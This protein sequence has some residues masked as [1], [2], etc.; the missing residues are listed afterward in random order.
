MPL[1]YEQEIIERAKILS[2]DINEYFE[3]EKYKQFTDEYQKEEITDRYLLNVAIELLISEL[4]DIGIESDQTV[5]DILEDPSQ[6]ET[7]FA[8]RTKFDKENFYQTLK[9]LSLDT[10]SEFLGVYENVELPEDLLLELGPW[11]SGKFPS[12]S[13]WVLIGYAINVWY[14]TNYFGDYLNEIRSMLLDR[15]DTNKAI[16][17]DA[18]ISSITKYLAQLDQLRS[19]LTAF[20]NAYAEKLKLNKDKLLKY[21]NNFDRGTQTMNFFKSSHYGLRHH[22]KHIRSLS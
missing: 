18:N 9:N 11:L 20:V 6:L 14:S 1:S 3:E 16:V 22:K 2:P 7:L 8:L 21:V 17:T 19:R 4:K 10:L 5:D 15:T 13:M 12:D